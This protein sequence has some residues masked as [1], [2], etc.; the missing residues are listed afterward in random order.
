MNRKG[1]SSASIVKRRLLAVVGDGFNNEKKEM[2]NGKEGF[3]NTVSGGNRNGINWLL[4]AIS[5]ANRTG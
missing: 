1:Y 3:A 5:S 2:K 4:S